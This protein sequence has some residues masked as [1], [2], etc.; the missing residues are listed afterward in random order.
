MAGILLLCVVQLHRRTLTA[1]ISIVCCTTSP[2][3]CQWPQAYCYCVLYN[4]AA[5]LPVA[6]GVLL[7]CIV[8]HRRR[9]LFALIPIVCCTTSPPYYP[10]SLVCFNCVLYNFSAVLPVASGV[11]LLCVVQHRHRT[12]TAMFQLCVVQLRR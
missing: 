10:W 9:T 6:S 1:L 11:L 4:I 7:L 2:P 3:Y 5:V 8:Q 12:L